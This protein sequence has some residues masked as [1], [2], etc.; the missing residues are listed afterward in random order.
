MVDELWQA[1]DGVIVPG[2]RVASQKSEY[3]PRGTIEM[4][5]PFFRDLGLDLAPYHSATLNV[6]IAPLTF[7]MQHPQYT[8]HNV[9]WTDAHPPEHFSF[10]PCRVTF[11]GQMHTG[12]IYYPHPETKER[13]FQNPSLVEVISEFIPGIGYGDGIRLEVRADQVEIRSP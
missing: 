6:S 1:V 7:A 10:S 4:Q 8:F 12:W 2:H 11:Q 3:Y 5:T 9:H 13:H